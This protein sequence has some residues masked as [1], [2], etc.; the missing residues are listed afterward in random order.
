M[1]VQN[2]LIE[3]SKEV[4]QSALDDEVIIMNMKTGEYHGAN[5]LGARIWKLLE[6]PITFN[7]LCNQLLE[8]YKVEKS[9]CEE[10][11]SRFLKM[12]LDKKLILTQN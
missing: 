2:T 10:E 5:V 9:V 1:I 7:S 6:T 8:E 12:L 3:R 11:T 4:L